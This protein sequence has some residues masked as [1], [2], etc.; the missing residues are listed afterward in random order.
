MANI[1]N[2]A[3]LSKPS[4]KLRWGT[5]LLWIVQLIPSL[6]IAI[7]GGFGRPAMRFLRRTSWVP[8]PSAR[9]LD[10]LLA[11]PARFSKHPL[12]RG[13]RRRAAELVWSPETYPELYL[14]GIPE[15]VRRPIWSDGRL[16]GGIS[17]AWLADKHVTPR[18]MRSALQG[19]VITAFALVV[20]LVTTKIALAW[21][22]VWDLAIIP[23]LSVTMPTIG[24]WPGEAPVPAM[25]G[26]SAIAFQAKAVA[27]ALIGTASA[28]AG[29]ALH[30]VALAVLGGILTWPL[31]IAAGRAG[32]ARRLLRATKDALTRYHQRAGQRDVEQR[33]Y[34]RQLETLLTREA[35]LPTFVLGTTTGTLRLRGVD[36]A[37]VADKPLVVSSQDLTTGILVFGG[38]GEG[39]SSGFARPLSAQLLASTDLRYGL[40]ALDA[41][42]VLWKD[43]GR[44][45]VQAGRTQ[46][47]R[48][49]GAGEGMIGLDL[50]ATLEPVQVALIFRGLAAQMGGGKGDSF[51]A[52]SAADLVLNV[53]TVLQAWEQTPAGDAYWRETDTR[54]YSLWGLY[55]ALASESF[56]FA[57]IR[58]LGEVMSDRESYE[59]VGQHIDAESLFSAL[60]YLT[61][62]WANMA[63]ATK[64]GVLANSRQILGPLSAVDGLRERFACG[65]AHPTSA[66]QRETLD[67][68]EAIDN[69]RVVLVAVSAVEA[70]SVARLII[71]LL[72][73]GLFATARLREIEIG[74]KEAQARPV[75]V[76]QDEVQE[77]VSADAT[78]GLSDSSFANVARSTGISLVMMTQG[79][80]ALFQS[81]GEEATQNLVNQLRTK[82]FLRTEDQDTLEYAKML[83]GR[84]MRTRV[85]KRGVFESVDEAIVAAKGAWHPEGDPD[86]NW[87]IWKINGSFLPQLSK[88]VAT[89]N[90]EPDEHA[91]MSVALDPL[92]LGTLDFDLEAL[93]DAGIELDPAFLQHPSSLQKMMA[94]EIPAEWYDLTQGNDVEDV[95][96]AN[97]V[98]SFGRF[99]AFVYA[100]R[101][102]A[103]R[104]DIIRLHH[105]F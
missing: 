93:Q 60:D 89:A 84:A 16:P 55:S 19:A 32:A 50:L 101:A 85:F 52:D 49:L 103:S 1:I 57:A 15:D 98:Y 64:S 11:I 63:A 75:V 3:A 73:A 104:A 62:A 92:H 105:R 30:V 23:D 77:I 97:D 20:G 81:I 27:T 5:T 90:A 45:A 69:G 88:L 28:W 54:P 17:L 22:L 94:G 99:H 38:T 13:D 8:M 29:I 61:D 102:G 40:W 80:S 53:L 76:L 33:T 4:H 37:P 70:G 95:L 68:R 51:W 35:G 24:A 91:Y 59:Q 100:M 86:P 7:S 2:L 65:S 31:L 25:T 39:K 14:S 18:L 43:I 44:M 42:A 67:I 46:D 96:S 71:M 58:D 36:T 6:I 87:G 66:Q 47:L 56:L 83:A 34:H 9:V 78:S 10:A 79:L 12:V 82:V 48:V 72:K 21:L 26:A 74:S 41:K